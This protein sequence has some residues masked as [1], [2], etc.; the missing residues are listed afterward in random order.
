LSRVTFRS[1][2]D[3]HSGDLNF[4]ENLIEPQRW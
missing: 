4:D 2:P 3:A 1:V